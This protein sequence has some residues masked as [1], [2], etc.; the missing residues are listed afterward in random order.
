MSGACS[1]SSISRDANAPGA[2]NGAAGSVTSLPRLLW[3]RRRLG[4]C[5]T[6]ERTAEDGQAETLLGARPLETVR[7]RC[8]GRE[9]VDADRAREN[10]L[11]AE[12]ALD[13]FGGGTAERGG[14]RQAL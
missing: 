4:R 13:G 11:L 1:P 6:E 12:L 5:R 8:H 7:R 14:E 9:P 10:A 3:R 2:H